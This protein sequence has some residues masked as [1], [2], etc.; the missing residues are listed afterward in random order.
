MKL[1]KGLLVASLV[2]SLSLFT[3]CSD[4][5]DNNDPAQTQFDLLSAYTDAHL[6]DWTASGWIKDASDVYN[7]LAARYVID[8]RSA[9]DYGTGHIEGAVNATPSTLLSVAGNAGGKTIAVVCYTG[10]TASWATMAL[11]MSGYA[12]AYAMKY[13]MSAWNQTYAGSWDG[14]CSDTYVADFVTTAPPALPTYDAPAL[15]GSQTSGADILADRVQAVLQGGF[16]TKTA[17]S[18]FAD[19]SGYNVINYWSEADY[20]TFGHIPGALQVSPGTLFADQ[21]LSVLDPAGQNVLYCWT[22]QTSGFMSFYLNVMGY[23]TYS[24]KFG[25]NSMIHGNLGGHAWGTGGIADYNYP[26]VTN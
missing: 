19:L 20:T 18:V 14:G 10:Q 9:A 24:L 6:A 12:D 8:M 7:N 5:D 23:E 13:G 15:S 1:L 3:G 26:V 21:N 25:A 2:T 16:L 11:R 4:D 17:A 22:G